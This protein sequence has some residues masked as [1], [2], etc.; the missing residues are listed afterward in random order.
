MMRAA[1]WGL[2]P[3]GISVLTVQGRSSGIARSVPVTPLSLGGSL[4]LVAPYGPVGWVRNLRAAGGGTLE[5]R[6]PH[7]IRAVEVD[8]GEAAPVLRAYLAQVPIV[9]EQFPIGPDAPVSAF[10]AIAG[11]YPVF[12]ITRAP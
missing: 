9:R 7:R 2:A 12:R 5:R 3:G 11:D 10:E 6:Q 8:G 1:R 4:Y